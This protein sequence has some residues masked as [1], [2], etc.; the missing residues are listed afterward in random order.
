[1]YDSNRAGGAAAS[2]NLALLMERFNAGEFD[3][4]VVGRALLN[5]SLWARKL[6]HGQPQ[7]PL[8]NARKK[9]LH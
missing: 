7:E 8:D 9:V 3:L 5:D 1:M 6:K 4:V 2:N